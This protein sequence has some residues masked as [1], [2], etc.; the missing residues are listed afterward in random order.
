MSYDFDFMP[1]NSILLLILF[2]PLESVKNIY[3][4]IGLGA[5]VA[6]PVETVQLEHESHVW[7]WKYHVHW[8]NSVAGKWE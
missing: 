1:R 2:Q 4:T 6:T 5:V 8:H 7:L 3:K